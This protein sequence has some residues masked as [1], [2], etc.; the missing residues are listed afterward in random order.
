MVRCYN[1]RTNITTA[2]MLNMPKGR[3][4]KGGVPK[5]KRCRAPASEPDVVVSR[6][7]LQV[8]STNASTTSC[9]N[10][11]TDTYPAFHINSPTF[12]YSTMLGPFPQRGPM[13]YGCPWSCPPPAPTTLTN[14]NPFYLK[15]ITGNIRTCQGCK[16]SLRCADS[17]IPGPPH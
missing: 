5:R 9:S 1:Q 14:P 6:P 16:G 17:S 12:H 13:A 8:P 10:S 15:M 3:G 7:S 2:G 4:Q 11:S